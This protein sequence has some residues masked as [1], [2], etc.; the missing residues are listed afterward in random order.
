M[1]HLYTGN[2]PQSC[3]YIYTILEAAADD[4]NANIYIL[5]IINLVERFVVVVVFVTPN[6][7]LISSYPIQSSASSYDNHAE[8]SRGFATP[9]AVIFAFLRFHQ[10]LIL[11]SSSRNCCLRSSFASWKGCVRDC[12]Q[13][14]KHSLM[15]PAQLA[16]PVA[17]IIAAAAVTFYTVSFLQMSQ[18]S[19][20]SCSY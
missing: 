19:H 10:A 20:I 15:D 9:W 17:A 12:L 11:H 2:V 6:L 5:C 7:L 13:E 16:V 4:D 3:S 8:K 18:V 1:E 14:G